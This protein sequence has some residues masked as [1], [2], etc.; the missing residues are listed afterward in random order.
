MKIGLQ[1]MNIF[2]EGSKHAGV[3]RTSLA[4]L[5]SILRHQEHQFVVFTRHDFEVPPHWTE[6]SNVEIVKSWSKTRSW[7]LIGRE[8]EILRHRLDAW[9]SVSGYVPRL[10]MKVKGSLVHD[11]FYRTYAETFT[12]HDRMI[13][14]HMSRNIA[15][16]ST[17]IASNS[18]ATTQ[19][20]SEA[21]KLPASKFVPLR[22]GIGQKIQD[23][24]SNVSDEELRQIGITNPNYIFSIST[25]EP[26]KNFPRLLEA[27]SKIAA[28]FP[29]TDLIIAGGKGWKEGETLDSLKKFGIE[30]RVK[31]LGYVPDEAVPK[32]FS[33]AS[34]AVTASLD[35][36]FGVPIL[37]ALH[38]GCPVACSDRPVMREIAGPLAVYF[39]PLSVDSI[40]EGLKTALTRGNRTVLVE[41]GYDSASLYSW[42]I[43]AQILLEHMRVMLAGRQ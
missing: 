26:R 25:L 13:H 40:S 11:I 22:F 17:F 27:F 39:D 12:E 9:F 28:E 14:E 3:S 7:A 15:R 20:F 5:E 35:E 37:E 38:F 33:R 32:L 34:F 10:P 4:L 16:H 41:K 8:L 2:L 29:E 19:A 31:F 1:A 24:A 43:S 42:D 23:R 18:A 6:Y 21:Y 30:N 36:G